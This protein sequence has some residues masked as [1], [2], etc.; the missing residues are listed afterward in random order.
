MEEQKEDLINR[1]NHYCKFNV[2]LESIDVVDLFCFN[3]GSCIKYA[4]RYR[5]K[6]TPVMDLEKA[7][8]YA[9]RIQNN[10][11][12]L[13]EAI[14]E[15]SDSKA[16]LQIFKDK[17]KDAITYETI[18]TLFQCLYDSSFSI[19]IDLLEIRLKFEKDFQEKKETIING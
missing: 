17:T 14:Q 16:V 5:D 8:F 7:L 9:K 19:L 18:N 6:G 2:E 13:N 12:K 1:P 4:L 10:E 15:L 11:R 3:L